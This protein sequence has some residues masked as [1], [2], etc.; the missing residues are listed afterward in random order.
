VETVTPWLVERV[1]TNDRAGTRIAWLTGAKVIS[2]FLLAPF[3][4]R[5][6]VPVA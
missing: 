1:L 6:I 5:E 4:K 3:R 2:R